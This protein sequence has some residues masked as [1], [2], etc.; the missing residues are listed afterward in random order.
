MRSQGGKLELVKIIAIQLFQGF[1][2]QDYRN[3]SNMTPFAKASNT[4][5]TVKQVVLVGKT[6]SLGV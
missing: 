5:I 3:F 6:I 1:N 2:A 4:T